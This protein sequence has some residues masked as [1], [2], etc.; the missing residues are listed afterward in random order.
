MTTKRFSSEKGCRNYYC[1]IRRKRILLDD[2]R[3]WDGRRKKMVRCL[4][5]L[6][7]IGRGRP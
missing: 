4:G 6:E 5:P 1:S 2:A 3:P 7:L